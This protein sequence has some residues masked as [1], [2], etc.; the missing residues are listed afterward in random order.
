MSAVFQAQ[1]FRQR[2]PFL[3]TESWGEIEADVCPTQRTTALGLHVVHCEVPI[4]LQV[5]INQLF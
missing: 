5:V 1:K 2:R 4:E 3:G